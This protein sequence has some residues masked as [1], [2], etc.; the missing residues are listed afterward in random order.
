METLTSAIDGDSPQSSFKQTMA[1]KEHQLLMVCF[2]LH[3]SATLVSFTGQLHWSA[4]LVSYTGQLHWSAT[5]VSYTGQLQSPI[6]VVGKHDVESIP[7]YRWNARL[8]PNTYTSPNNFD[9]LVII[10]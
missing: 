2:T 3:W 10:R 8:P 6:A 1:Y 7:R 4:S 9:V 5:L